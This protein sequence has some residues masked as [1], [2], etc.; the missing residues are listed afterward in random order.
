[1]AR[2]YQGKLGYPRVSYTVQASGGGGGAFP[3]YVPAVFSVTLGAGVGSAAPYRYVA[4]SAVEGLRTIDYLG[5]A[6]PLFG[7]HSA[8]TS[9]LA[10]VVSNS[11]YCRDAGRLPVSK[12]AAASSAFIGAA[13]M[14]GAAVGELQVKCAP[15]GKQRAWSPK[16]RGRTP[17]PRAV[18]LPRLTPTPHAG[19]HLGRR[20]A[21]DRFCIARAA[22]RR[23]GV[24]RRRPARRRDAAGGRSARCGG[25]ARRD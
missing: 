13:T 10:P 19:A 4:S 11:S 14:M 25:R 8:S 20:D 21:V 6:L 23:G 3:D 2:L 9:A 12:V 16:R 22:I 17:T 7:R 1:M 15:R 5:L 24:P 18:A